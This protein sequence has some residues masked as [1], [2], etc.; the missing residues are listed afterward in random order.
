MLEKDALAIALEKT[1]A[2]GIVDLNAEEVSILPIQRERQ[3]EASSG[4][5]SAF[6]ETEIINTLEFSNFWR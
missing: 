4:P 6:C 5:P 1:L 2:H 3:V